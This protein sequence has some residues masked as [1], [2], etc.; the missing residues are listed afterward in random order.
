M[1]NSRASGVALASLLSISR[2]A[3]AQPP[4]PPVAPA[5]PVAG[6]PDPA[7]K[8]EAQDHFEKGLALAD[9]EQW[10][11]A[12]A[13]FQASR[14]LYPS[15]SAI[16][17]AGVCL[18]KLNRLDE[19]LDTFEGLLRD[20]KELAADIKAEAQKNVVELRALVGTLEIE[21][22]EPGAS[23]TVDGRRRGEHPLASP[24]RV[25]VGSHVVR[26]YREGY[27]PFEATVEVAGA[28]SA[29]VAAKLPKL[30]LSERLEVVEKGGKT[31]D[32][33]IDGNVVGQTPWQGPVA[34]GAHT[35]MLRGEERLGSLP[36]Q[37]EVA[38]GKP[39]K[40]ALAAEELDA[41][42]HVAPQPAIASV[43]I[44]GIFVGR[45]G[46]EGHLRPGSHT[47]T[48][49]ADGYFKAER[50]VV[51]GRGQGQTV[52]V[53]LERDPKSPVWRK[54]G[55][56]LFELEGALAVS[57]SLGGDVSKGC[58]GKCSRGPAF[59]EIGAFHAGYEL[60]SGF[61]FG[62]ELGYARIAQTTSDRA[63]GLSA[64]G[65]ASP[66]AG[67]VT[68]ALK[69]RGFLAGAFASLRLGEKVPVRFKLGAG[70]L[71]GNLADSR[72][73]SF[74]TSKGSAFDVGPLVQS[75]ASNWFFLDPEVRVGL[76]LGGHVELSA[77][78]GALVLV[79]SSAASW[80][81]K[82][83]VNAG[84][85]GYATFAS[86]TLTSSVLVAVTPSLEARYDF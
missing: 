43:A 24:L 53:A 64:V 49:V 4:P 19:A 55:R 59:G 58:T 31:L 65:I 39:G 14:R 10:D 16:K 48:L 38:Q 35:V 46:Y 63:L 23:I 30:L 67:S 86:E 20:Y 3:A 42:L 78:V 1:I 25:A 11:A 75:Q 2:L 45:G 28:Q 27:E 74:T 54:P 66:D 22:A 12:L 71:I 21:G 57:P 81:G 85:D 36:S 50:P 18:R 72:T 34:V 76:R 41:T 77:G 84:A 47:I 13:E 44:D 8:K 61:G 17:N 15:R 52:N 70:G 68:D 33:V 29:K 51:L 26:L 60:G 56:F 73:G 79:G 7:R 5:P 82:T 69:L 32:V 83:P 9:R 37:I 80:N 40:V 62:V 6:E